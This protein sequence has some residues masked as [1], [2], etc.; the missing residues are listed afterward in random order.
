MAYCYVW[1]TL[2]YLCLL[3]SLVNNSAKIIDRLVNGQVVLLFLILL[4]LPIHRYPLSLTR[5]WEN[6]KIKFQHVKLTLYEKWHMG[7]EDEEYDKGTGITNL[8][9]AAGALYWFG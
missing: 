2:L 1:V 4:R 8:M 9:A 6:F 5:S 7:R 3:I